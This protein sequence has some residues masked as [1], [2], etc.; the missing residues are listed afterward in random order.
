MADPDELGDHH[1]PEPEHEDDEVHEK[2]PPQEDEV[3]DNGRAKVPLHLLH[4]PL[5]QLI[6]KQNPKTA[7][8]LGPALR[9]GGWEGRREGGREGGRGEG[10]GREGGCGL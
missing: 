8:D 6:A 4:V 5:P 2:E 9:Q 3:G 1:K 10:G 7:L